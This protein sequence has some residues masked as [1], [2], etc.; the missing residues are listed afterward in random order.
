MDAPEVWG[1]LEGI[2]SVAA[3]KGVVTA[4]SLA[5]DQRFLNWWRRGRIELPVQK[6][7]GRDLLQA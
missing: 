3:E 7:Y 2:W 1:L 4:E 6:T 5:D